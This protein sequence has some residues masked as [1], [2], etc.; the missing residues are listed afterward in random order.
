MICDIW[1]MA[2][3]VFSFL[4]VKVWER[5]CFKDWE[6]MEDLDTEWIN[7]KGVCRTAPAT[8]GLFFTGKRLKLL[9]VEMWIG[10]LPFGSGITRF[11]GLGMRHFYI[12][13][14][15]FY[16]TYLWDILWLNWTDDWTRTF[17]N[18]D[19]VIMLIGSLVFKGRGRSK[20]LF[21]S[22]QFFSDW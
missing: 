8:P 16:E 12:L 14:K 2:W 9:E 5:Q 11:P 6:E 1:H 21:K 7:Y 3:G 4:A 22:L 10:G 15:D 20:L 13:M 19:M 17:K 18:F